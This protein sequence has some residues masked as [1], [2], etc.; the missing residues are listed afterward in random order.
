VALAGARGLVTGASGGI[1]RAVAVALARQGVV[2]ALH[3][4]DV[5][6]LAVTAAATGGHCLVADLTEPGAPVSL[7]KQAEE[8][9]GG[10][11]ILVAGAGAGWAGPFASMTD[12]AV[13][14]IIGLD[15]V[16]P[17]ELARALVPAMAA[18]GRGCLVFVGSVAG[19]VGVPGES[20]YS[21]AKAGLVGLADSLRAELA[22]SGITVSV[23]SPGPVSTA[24][25]DRRGVPYTRRFPRPVPPERVAAA[26][27]TAVGSGRPELLVP[28]W[29]SVAVRLRGAAPAMYRRLASWAT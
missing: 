3:G 5:D 6:A 12:A 21:A 17:T 24:F 15:L 26:V 16:A 7:A 1:G 19:H 28:R 22:S 14:R 25:F 27:V 9:L 10:V 23:V 8:H 11:D 29:L 2:L 13:E 4:R 18:R 20:V